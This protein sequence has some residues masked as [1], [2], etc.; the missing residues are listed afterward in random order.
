M[1]FSSNFPDLTQLKTEYID[2]DVAYRHGLHLV[3]NDM[4]TLTTHRG[5]TYYFEVED[6][7][8]DFQV[9]ISLE[10]N[11]L[12]H[13]CNCRSLR[14]CCPHAAAAL[15]MLG[16]ELTRKEE[17][18][19]TGGEAYSRSEMIERVLQEREERAEKEDFQI[20]F[21]D[22][23]YGFHHIKTAAGRIYE[24]TIRD[25]KNNSG[26]CS[27]PDFKTNKL[28]T[29]KH[30]I[31][32]HKQIG[33][34]FPVK[35]LM[36]SQPYPFV[37]VYCDPLNEYHIT[38]FYKG[39]PEPEIESLLEKYFD[40]DRY[41][42]PEKYKAFL[43]FLKEAQD[44]KKILIRPEVP[45]KIDK[46]F[47][48]QLYQKL[49]RDIAPDFGKL[50]ARLFDYQKEGVIFSLF[51]QGS[52]IADEMG[53]GKTLQ[54][55]ATAVLKKDI[56]DLGRTLIICPASL[57][58][59]WATEIKR[60]S[61]EEAVIVEGTRL[62]RHQIYRKSDAFFL[63]TNYEAVL[64]DITVI[65]K[66]PPDMII[67]DEA[68][69][70]KNYTTKTS[71]AVKA[72][73]KKHSLVITG[74]PIENRLGDLYSIMNFIDPEIL[75]PLW[76]FSMN[77]CYFDK[78]KKYKI[79]GYYNLQSLKNR[80]SSSIIRRQKKDVLKQLPAVQEVNVPIDLYAEQQEMHSGFARA[81]APILAKKHKTFYDMQRIFQLLTNMRMVCNSTY[82][83]D[84]ETNISPKLDELKEILL[85][86]LDIV[87]QRK[88][89]IIFSEWK[90]MLHLIEKLLKTNQVGYAKL[91]G[92][93]P[94]KNRGRLIE[95]FSHNPDCLVFL[96]TEAGGTG[97]NLQVADTVINVELPWNPARKNQRI[98]RVHRIG[99]ESSKITAINLVARRS[100]EERIAAG[101][102]LKES[103]FDAVLNEGD[104]TDEV[105]F[106]ARGR[107]TFIEQI[108]KLVEPFEAFAEEE[109]PEAEEQIEAA[110]AETLVEL[111]EEEGEEVAVTE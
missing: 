65:R 58:Y 51:K 16:E 95:E 5:N 14:K 59:Q 39:D 107:S 60:F 67:L 72:I 41:I 81:L 32:A 18:P 108:Q 10:D 48:Q 64:R 27:C 86:K 47:E 105:D 38:Y 83:I 19:V 43:H 104:L 70:I 45:A 89:V 40:G 80:L 25:W 63:I 99:Q 13:S 57:K 75:A 74:T 35:E 54:A 66:F 90:T 78:S 103:L 88:K 76:E 3:E 33:K 69:R 84:R 15:I 68:Q 24:V 30:L 77:H 101:I 9:E 82:L 49:S 106:S 52:I 21:G 17:P 94:V 1:K 26:Y 12:K 97:L 50:K 110:P 109:E 92:D 7:F 93:V 85:E 4:C 71:Y 111:G 100:I 8:E 22:N 61:S 79:T 102:V 96:A 56:F 36:Q 55:I 37:E 34:K 2:S 98:G 31:F 91:T 44:F 6:R 87:G 62:E 46:Y 11:N 29:C 73:P 20:S 42:L 28:G 53:L 23:I